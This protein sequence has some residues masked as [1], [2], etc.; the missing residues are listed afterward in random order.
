MDTKGMNFPALPNEPLVGYWV[1]KPYWNLGICSEALKL[2]IDY[3]GKHTDISSLIC[4]HFA[5]NPASG[6]VMRKCG[7][8]PTGEVCFDETLYAGEDRPIILMRRS[9]RD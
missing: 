3:I 8:V 2:M 9:I 1:A 6:Q 7:F 4:G 5:D